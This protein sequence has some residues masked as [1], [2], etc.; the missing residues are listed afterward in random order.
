[1]GNGGQLPACCWDFSAAWR[2]AGVAVFRPFSDPYYWSTV[3]VFDARHRG[4][5]S[6]MVAIMSPMSVRKRP[7]QSVAQVVVGTANRHNRP[8][9]LNTVLR[10]AMVSDKVRQQ[11]GPSLD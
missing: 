6:G 11:R 2:S 10:R 1:M 8:L 9:P 3:P 7:L 4:G 5:V